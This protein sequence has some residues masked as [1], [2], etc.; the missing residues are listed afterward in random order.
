MAQSPR[1]WI[2]Q[3]KTPLW[4]YSR[5]ANQ[6]LAALFST[7]GGPLSLWQTWKTTMTA[8]GNLAHLPSHKCRNGCLNLNFWQASGLPKAEGEHSGAWLEEGCICNLPFQ[9]TH[10]NCACRKGCTWPLIPASSL[11]PSGT[12]SSSFRPQLLMQ[13]L[14]QGWKE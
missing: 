11:H 1:L 12:F 5:L 8:L 13:N 9:L 4:L 7:Q 10:Q 3:T 14:R 2:F 6:N